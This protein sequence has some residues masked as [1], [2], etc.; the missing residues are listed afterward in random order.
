MSA[1]HP[2]NRKVITTICILFATQFLAAQKTD[3]TRFKNGHYCVFDRGKDGFPINPIEYYDTTGVLTHTRSYR[4]QMLDGPLTVYDREG[5][6]TE[7]IAYKGGLKHGNNIQYFPDGSIHNIWTFRM[8]EVHGN[9]RTYH[10]NGQLEWS[11]GLK[12]GRLHGLRVLRDSTGAKFNGEYTT[13]FPLNRGYYTTSN[14]NG[15]PHGKFS[16]MR[17]DSTMNYTGY[18][19][20]GYPDGEYIYYDKAGKVRYRDYYNKG[21]FVES[22][23]GDGKSISEPKPL[24]DEPH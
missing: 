5:R 20:K 19:N 10:P 1:I 22:I 16:V 9:G 21:K 13:N 15:R 4:G 14:I 17:S 11:M 8:G 2:L 18:F 24:D 6:K 3:T 23:Q 7:L 12:S